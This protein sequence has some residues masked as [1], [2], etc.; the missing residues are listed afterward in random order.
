M[1]QNKTTTTKEN[2]ERRQKKKKRNK[3]EIIT[4]NKRECVIEA[5]DKNEGW[6]Q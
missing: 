5:K 1:K 3:K 2:K 6:S 4:V